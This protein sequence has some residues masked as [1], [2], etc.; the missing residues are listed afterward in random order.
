MENKKI[1]VEITTPADIRRVWERWTAPQHIVKWNFASEDWH[2]PHAE[3]DLRTGGKFRY[4]M[5]SVDG[6]MSFDFEGTYNEVTDHRSI[7]YSLVNGRK[8]SIAFETSGDM[9]RITEEF[10][11]EEINS[12]EL[13]RSGWQ[14]ILNNF[15]QYVETN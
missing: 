3:N 12:A 6:K 10:D 4:T 9:T 2:C 7:A 5:A 11:P 13:Q 15:K 8:V 1:N 14:A